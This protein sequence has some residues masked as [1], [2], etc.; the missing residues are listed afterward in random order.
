M[1]ITA[2]IFPDAFHSDEQGGDY[3]AG[4][5]PVRRQAPDSRPLWFFVETNLSF[6][7]VLGCLIFGP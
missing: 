1:Y 4:K 6:W 7:S 5:S 3:I 2:H